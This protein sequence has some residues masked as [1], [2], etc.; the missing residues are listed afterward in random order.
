MG[1][2]LMSNTGSCPY[3]VGD[4]F[5]TK[6]SKN[7]SERWPGTT[8]TQIKDV[9]L[10]S[11]GDTYEVDATGGEATH[12]LTMPETPKHNHA[13]A[14]YQR[15]YPGSIGEP[16]LYITPVGIKPYNGNTKYGGTECSYSGGDQPH[17]NMPPYL[18]RIYWERT[19]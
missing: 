9:F 5:W 8:W 2:S 15:G 1:K 19:A 6:N 7:P 17:N 4:G 11:A 18:V 13:Y 12:K 14:S 10:L 3:D 16:E